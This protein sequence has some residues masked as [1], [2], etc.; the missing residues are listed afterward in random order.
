MQ[1]Q[2][3]R[4]TRIKGTNIMRKHLL[5]ILLAIL[6]SI[7]SVDAAIVNGF[8]GKQYDEANLTWW[9]NTKDS[10]LTIYGEGHMYDWGSASN[11]PWYDYRSYIRTI[12]IGDTVAHIG[13]YAFSELNN[14][15]EIRIPSSIVSIGSFAFNKCSALTNV[16]IAN[17]AT[18]C[19]I[20]LG[21]DYANPI[22]YSKGFTINGNTVSDLVIPNNVSDIKQ[23][24][25]N[26]SQ[27]LTTITIPQ[28]VKTIE[29]GAFESC[30]HLTSV[31]IAEG[32][33]SIGAFAFRY[34]KG[35]QSITIPNSVTSLGNNAFY[36]CESMTTATI[37]N[38]VSAIGAQAF[39]GCS[40]LVSVTLGSSVTSLGENAFGQCSDLV[41][42]TMQNPTAPLTG[43]NCSLDPTNCNLYVPYNSVT[44]YANALWWEDF[45]TIRSIGSCPIASGSCGEELTWELSCDYELSISGAGALAIPTEDN[46][47]WYHYRNIIKSVNLADG[48]TS[49]CDYAFYNCS[50]L[51]SV[52]IPNSVTNTGA[53]AFSGCSGLT[54]VTIG[55]NV[56]NIGDYAFSD[57]SSLTSI[58]IPNN[59]TSIGDDAFSGCSNLTSVIWDAKECADAV[60]DRHSPFYA[61]RSQIASFIFGNEVE[62]IPTYLC[63]GMNNLTS[64]SLPDNI[65]N[66]GNYAFSSCSNLT[67]ITNH[68]VTPQTISSNVFKNVNKSS[69]TLYVPQTSLELYRAKNVWKDFT[70]IQSIP[71]TSIT[72]TITFKDWDGTIL[73]SEE[74]EEGAIPTPPADPTKT[75]DELY[76]YTFAG[77]IPEI[78]AVTAD[79][80]YTAQYDVTPLVQDESTIATIDLSTAITT[81]SSNCTVEWTIT[82]NELNVEYTTPSAWK[83]V[84]VEFPLPENIEEIINISFEYYGNGENIVL[85]PYLRDSEKKRWTKSDYF[86]NLK[87]TEWLSV[88]TY[89]PDK[90]LWDNADYAYGERP[91]TKIGFA[92]NPGTDGSG[93]FNVRNVKI[94]YIAKAQAA[95]YTV[96]FVNWDGTVLQTEEVEEGAYPTAPANP[97]KPETGEYTYSF[98]GWSP[99]IVVV[100]EPATYTATYTATHLIVPTELSLTSAGYN[101]TDNVVLCV[102]FTGDATVCND[103]LLAGN[104]NGWNTTISEMFKFMLLAGFDG[105]YAAE[106]PFEV[107]KDSNG[108]DVYPQGKPIQLDNEGKFGWDNQCGDP[109]AWTHKGGNNADISWGFDYEA[110]ITY[111]SAGAYIYEMSYWKKHINPCAAILRHDYTIRLYAPDACEEMK[112][113]VIGDF[114]NWSEGIPMTEQT[115]GNGRTFY[116]ATFNDKEGHTFKIREVEAYDWINQLQYKTEDGS[117]S[118]FDN[119][120]LGTNEIITLDWSDNAKY[121]FAQCEVTLPTEYVV[122][123]LDRY[124]THIDEEMIS[125]HLPEAPEIE[126]FTFIGWQTVSAFIQEGI[127]IQAVY[128]ANQT[129]SAPEVVNPANKA[130]KLIR[131]GNVYILTDTKTYTAQGQEVR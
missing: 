19:E 60:F 58:T 15:R 89:L 116:T 28:S 75:D 33:T 121:R 14:L 96:T 43:T 87:K 92:A 119:I 31:S 63:Y 106:F 126:G 42:L 123:Y 99:E 23:Y 69:C 85:Y 21:N 64:I 47:P 79:A 25:F 120:P 68:S 109:D 10:T 27:N 3:L 53:R 54:S 7:S 4:P 30:R 13:K 52:T 38:G 131:N 76:S 72:Y 32:V 82:D 39:Y 48:V 105:W 117:W 62:Y 130:Q 36:G 61:V 11:V 9:L 29:K 88:T 16:D 71:S 44:N 50:A 78:T 104:Y 6:T 65:T 115:D 1:A 95:T 111:N 90:L 125:L 91:F 41:M 84:G 55:N 127:S 128:E 81:S 67:S 70:N 8:C 12:N 5:Y 73:K 107:T 20:S 98:N 57:C 97:S 83:V 59:V 113:A 122:T 18:W 74:L 35:L 100:T 93:S 56:T 124:N 118:D 101:T 22:T 114:N 2:K 112:P 46:S 40:S 103:I 80:T 26:C 108:D 77:W 102:K 45:A 86:I 66:I 17:I 24:V 49:I 129:T 110:N 37:G 34:C 94:E 51:T